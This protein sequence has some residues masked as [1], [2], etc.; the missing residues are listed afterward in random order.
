MFNIELFKIDLGPTAGKIHKFI[1][2]PRVPY[3]F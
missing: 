2:G 3:G 1:G